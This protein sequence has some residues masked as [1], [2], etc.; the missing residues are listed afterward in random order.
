M[1][2][3]RSIGVSAQEF[4][5]QSGLIRPSLTKRPERTIHSDLCFLEEAHD[6]YEYE[7][8]DEESGNG[9]LLDRRY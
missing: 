9:R 4:R 7:G 2:K 6:S 1:I 8:Y 3:S 5:H